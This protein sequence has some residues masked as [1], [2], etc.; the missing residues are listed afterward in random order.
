M[1][2]ASSSPRRRAALTV[3]LLRGLELPTQF[4][5]TIVAAN[6]MGPELFGSFGILLAF[7]A[8]LVVAAAYGY[9]ELLQ[10][11]I[12]RDPA[13]LK[14]HATLAL[15]ARTRSALL[16]LVVG[17]IAA[18]VLAA[19][20]SRMDLA[21]AVV[22]LAGA[23]AANL[24]S[25]MF[26]S[27]AVS[28][29]SVVIP[30]SASLLSWVAPLVLA[31]S[32]LVVSLPTY[33]GALA[34]GAFIRLVL[35]LL[36]AIK[37]M[38]LGETLRDSLRFNL[39][40]RLLEDRK[41]HLSIVLYSLNNQVLARHGDMLVA[42]L[43]GVSLSLLGSYS[44]AFQITA[45]ANSFLMMG[46]GTVAL[47]YLSEQSATP[48]K[49]GIAWRK[50]SAVAAIIAVG[51]ISVLALVAPEMVAL[52]F[53]GEYPFLT[54][55]ILA[56]CIAQWANRV[57]G[58]GTNTGS[59]I[60]AGM[61]ATVARSSVGGAILNILLNFAFVPWLG[62][63]GLV[64]GTAVSLLSVGIMNSVTLSRKLQVKPPVLLLAC[65]TC[66]VAASVA[67]TSLGAELPWRAGLAFV[68]LSGWAVTVFHT[69]KRIKV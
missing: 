8:L 39:R 62:V 51:P 68:V 15:G 17:A 48:D 11:A 23:S 35:T 41:S 32:G 60:A 36:W 53:R 24:V 43:L 44:L 69:V 34:L 13:Q 4:L 57:G 21:I 22:L 33:G 37:R 10:R 18:G 47:S 50:I 52:V 63:F 12:G 5:L 6:T 7:Q 25:T 59:L 3:Q 54:E 45:M 42:G 64:V 61:S 1:L 46:F 26:T 56:L 40:L 30:F 20:M 67:I 49:L 29:S 55:L 28:T 14:V 27:I 9:D 2:K 38:Y 58:G 16:V 19:S 65:L 66:C 31:L